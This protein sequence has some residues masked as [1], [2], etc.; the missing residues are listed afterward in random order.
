MN[1][2]SPAFLE[3]TELRIVARLS[4]EVESPLQ[5]TLGQALVKGDKI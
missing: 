2:K 1:A 4:N 3:H 5:L